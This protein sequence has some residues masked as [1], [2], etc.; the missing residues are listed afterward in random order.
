MGNNPGEDIVNVWLQEVELLFTMSN[1]NV[2]KKTKVLEDGKKRGGG[3]GKEIDILAVSNDG[4]RKVWIEISVSPN[5]RIDSANKVVESH[6][7]KV[8][9]KFSEEATEKVREIFGTDKFER[10]FVYSPRLFA[11]NT[12]RENKFRQELE[13]MKIKPISFENVFSKIIEK[14]NHYSTDPTKVYLYYLKFFNIRELKR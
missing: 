9:K 7:E 6:V 12:T 10:W 14:L 1:I 4:R 8:K 5:P 3:R 2:P 11:K 13:S